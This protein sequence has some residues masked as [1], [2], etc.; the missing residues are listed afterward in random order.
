MHIDNILQE[1]GERYGAFEANAAT[2][3][4][5]KKVLHKSKNWNKLS[6]V[7]KEG[8]EMIQYKIAR[9]LNGDHFYID[10]VVDIVG[11]SNL[12]KDSMEKICEQKTQMD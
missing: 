10:N 7:Q 8:L 2:A 5:L 12:I 1:R 4:A 3:Q 9:I 6:D 11:Y